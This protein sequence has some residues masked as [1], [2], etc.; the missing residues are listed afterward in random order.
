MTQIRHPKIAKR[1]LFV[2]EKNLT[3][4]ERGEIPRSCLDQQ[5]VPEDMTLMYRL[6]AETKKRI[7]KIIF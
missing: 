2:Y 1:S 7:S 5:K 3:R 6:W 4:V